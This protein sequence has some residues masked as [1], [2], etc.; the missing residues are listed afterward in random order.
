M[1]N[2]IIAGIISVSLLSIFSSSFAASYGK[3]AGASCMVIEGTI[4]AVDKTKN[5]FVIKD[6]DDGKTYGLGAFASQ[7]ASLHEGENVK[8]TVP[9]PGSLVSK[10]TK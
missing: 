3:S 9:V 1:K 7:I 6:K 2:I 4:V 10:I 8:V 5:L